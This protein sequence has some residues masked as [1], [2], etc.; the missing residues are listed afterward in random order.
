MK[1]HLRFMQLEVSTMG[2]MLALGALLAFVLL[3]RQVRVM[4]L[5]DNLSLRLYLIILVSSVIGSKCFYIVSTALLTLN[6]NSGFSWMTLHGSAS[7]GAIIAASLSVL[8]YGRWTGTNGLTLL[9]CVAPSWAILTVFGR[10]GCLAAGCCFGTPTTSA[11]AVVFDSSTPAGQAFPETPL[12][13]TQAVQAF[14]A[15]IAAAASLA[16]MGKRHVPG[17]VFSSLL[18]YFGF[19][20][21]IIDFFRYQGEQGLAS[22]VP[23][24][25]GIPLSQLLGA[26]FAIIGSFSL[27]ALSLQRNRLS[28]SCRA[29]GRL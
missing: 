14:G 21:A 20:R 3:V 11:F 7:M 25:L 1:P 19:E 16:L 18:L 13:P 12:I 28:P 29:R 27:V 8:A 17:V 26:A 2:V 4:K 5:P 10:V 9:D 6:G 23:R 24:V 22:D 15:L